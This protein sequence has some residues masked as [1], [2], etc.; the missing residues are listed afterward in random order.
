MQTT[1]VH[2]SLLN[3]V[4]VIKYLE[5]VI[6]IHATYVCFKIVASLC[7]VAP[8]PKSNLVAHPE[9]KLYHEEAYM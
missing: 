5:N 6:V 7:S 3:C 9:Y 2:A 4:Y 1:K 8:T